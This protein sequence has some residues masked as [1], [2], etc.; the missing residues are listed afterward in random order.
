MDEDFEFTK[1]LS[2]LRRQFNI[3]Q[4]GTL[5]ERKAAIKEIEEYLNEWK[6]DL[7]DDEMDNIMVEFSKI[8]LQSFSDPSDLIRETSIRILREILSRLGDL[9]QHLKYIFSMLVER[10]NCDDLEGIR[11]MDEKMIPDPGQKPKLLSE[12]IE[13]SEVARIELLE[14]FSTLIECMDEA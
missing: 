10:T 14:L 5:V 11:G 8:L 1:I 6:V 12:V 2:H 4:Q 13:T 3:L 9:D 7:E